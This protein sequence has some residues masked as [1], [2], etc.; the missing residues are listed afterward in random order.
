M[1]LDDTKDQGNYYSEKSSDILRQLGF[2]GIAIFWIFKNDKALHDK[3]LVPLALIL[4][5]L[6]IDLF[7]YLYGTIVYRIHHVRMSKQTNMDRSV[8]FTIRRLAIVPITIA[9]WIKALLTA[10][11]YVTSLYHLSGTL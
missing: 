7:Q 6:S 4:V 1:N 11:S 10:A 9:F 2:A 8:E 5:A 3:L